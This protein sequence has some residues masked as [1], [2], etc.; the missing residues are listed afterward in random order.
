MKFGAV[1]EQLLNAIDL[2]LPPEPFINTLV[3][4]GRRKP[5]PKV[6]IGASTWGAPSWNGLVFPPRT[7]AN[8]FRLFYP[9]YFSAIEL[10]ATH[11][12]IYPPELLQ[13]WAAPAR[14]RDFR[15]CPKFPQEI[16]HYS[17][18]GPAA[19]GST[20]AFLDS[21]RVFGANLGPLFL[22]LS[23]S[24]SPAGREA[25]YAYLA[26]LPK[27]LSFF[28]ELR[29]PGWFGDAAVKEDLFNT[30]RQLG[31]GAVITDSPGRRD[32]VHMH[33]AIPKLFVRFVCNG[34][35]PSSFRRTDEWV[36]RLQAWLD[37]GLE[38]AYF[39]LHPGEDEAVPQ[40]A[41]YWTREVNARC[42]LAL[43]DPTTA[44]RGLFGF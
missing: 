26:G 18:F 6:Y 31:I 12:R 7:P 40:L 2:H 19:S 34:L 14:G 33:L 21:I 37:A 20:L 39:F 16:S 13:P 15:L 32:A 23:E 36:G 38:E 9:N 1:P 30:L 4:T 29:H 22:Q 10:N 3:L 5:A 25:L 17:N 42:G 8:K 11:Y 44:Q 27:D 41:S 28:L 24:Y 43:K 35:H